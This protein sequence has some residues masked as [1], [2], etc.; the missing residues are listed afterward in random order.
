[1]AASSK[2]AS[3]VDL[4]DLEDESR[5]LLNVVFGYYMGGKSCR[6]QLCTVCIE[7]PKDFHYIVKS[8]GTGSGIYR[9][10]KKTLPNSTTNTFLDTSTRTSSKLGGFSGVK[11]TGVKSDY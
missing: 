5:R 6:M 4:Q 11:V 2:L 10:V 8:V 3:I 9:C 1:M 7:C